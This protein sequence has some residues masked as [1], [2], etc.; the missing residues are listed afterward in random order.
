MKTKL[1]ILFLTI[2]SVFGI[3]QENMYKYSNE[4]QST[5]E[6]IE[7]VE[8]LIQQTFG[9]PSS[10]GIWTSKSA[11]YGL[12]I[13]TKGNTFTIRAWQISPNSDIKSKIES[14]MAQ[15]EPQL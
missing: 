15:V 13:R 6:K 2:F 8:S 1:L 3:A 5:P 10:P 7:K 9:E 4:I 11:D 14:L 12:I